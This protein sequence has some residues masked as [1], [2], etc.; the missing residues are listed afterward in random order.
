MHYAG[1]RKRHKKKREVDKKILH[2]ISDWIGKES[3]IRRKWG[4]KNI[5]KSGWMFIYGVD[6]M[7]Q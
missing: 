1:K 4:E 7:A 6:Y 2:L 3:E 5:G